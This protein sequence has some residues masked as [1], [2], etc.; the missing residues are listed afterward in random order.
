MHGAKF[1]MIYKV[2]QSTI[3]GQE[4]EGEITHPVSSGKLH[5]NTIMTSLQRKLRVY[6][7][8]LK[9]RNAFGKWCDIVA[10]DCQKYQE[11]K[12]EKQVHRLGKDEGKLDIHESE[13]QAQSLDCPVTAIPTI[14]LRSSA[15]QD[16]AEI[17]SPNF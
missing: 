5:V 16:R 10:D 1:S 9:L 7:H 17:I 8:F 2:P 15:F 11:P 3:N 14:S 13:V 12:M 6:W 4:P